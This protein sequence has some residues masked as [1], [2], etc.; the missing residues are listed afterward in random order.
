[1]QVYGIFLIYYLQFGPR[2]YGTLVYYHF[3][4]WF[5]IRVFNPCIV[6]SIHVQLLVI[7]ISF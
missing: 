6:A 7:I 1:M 2:F 3:L 4:A 5:I